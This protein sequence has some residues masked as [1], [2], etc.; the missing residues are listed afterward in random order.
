MIGEVIKCHNDGC[1]EV[2]TKKTHNQIYHDAEC[3]R[4]A[5]NAKI[6]NKY[7][8]KRARVLG[9]ARYCTQCD[10]KL[11]RYNSETICN[12]CSLTRETNK[13]QSVLN[14]ISDTVIA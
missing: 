14:M 11:S 12:S 13:N 6:M 8:A 9:L 1:E 10:T 5:T 2:F 3:M 7:Y 4:L